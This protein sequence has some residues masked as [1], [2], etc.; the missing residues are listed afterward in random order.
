MIP[1]H[2][3]AVYIFITYLSTTYYNVFPIFPEFHVTAT[4]FL[5]HT[6]AVQFSFPGKQLHVQLKASSPGNVYSSL[7]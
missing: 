7:Q 5:G 1:G 4:S 6:S 3:T 2:F